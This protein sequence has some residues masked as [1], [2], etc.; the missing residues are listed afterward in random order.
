[1]YERE[2]TSLIRADFDE[3]KEY[4]QSEDLDDKN[5][6]FREDKGKEVND[7]EGIDAEESRQKICV[8]S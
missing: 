4:K 2:F 1:M 7:M 6:Y 3:E 5:V 8:R